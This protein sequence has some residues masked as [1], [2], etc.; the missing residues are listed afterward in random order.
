MPHKQTK[1]NTSNGEKNFAPFL[2]CFL[3]LFFFFG[4]L[5]SED[6]LK[7]VLFHGA[8]ASAPLPPWI[9]KVKRVLLRHSPV[10]DFFTVP[11]RLWCV[12]LVIPTHWNGE[13]NLDTN[14]SFIF[15]LIV[16]LHWWISN[17]WIAIFTI[18]KKWLNIS[19]LTLELPEIFLKFYE[20]YF[21]PECLFKTI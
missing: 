13:W 9:V 14:I 19:F 11:S 6:F 5:Y 18:S 12:L 2:R 10:F 4:C 15:F 16:W 20:K 7:E 8:V 3:L 21:I 17:L 1:I